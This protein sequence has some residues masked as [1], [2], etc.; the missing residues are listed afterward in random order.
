MRLRFDE[1][2]LDT[3]RFELCRNGQA[4]NIE[5]KVFD[6]LALL[7][8]HPE[9]LFSRE[10]L[11]ARV[12]HGRLVSDTTISTC[13]KGA[14]KALNDSGS[15]QTYI[16]TVRG[17]GFCFIG[18]VHRQEGQQT[19]AAASDTPPER[20]RSQAQ[21]TPTL[22][23]LPFKSITD[24]ADATTLA[25]SLGSDISAILTRLPLLRVQNRT[26]PGSESL[27]P[28]AVR[29]LHE[30]QGIDFVVDAGIQRTDDRFR[31]VIQLTD[32]RSG[33]QLWSEQFTITGPLSTAIDEAMIAIIAKLEPQLNRSI[34]DRVTAAKDS[35]PNARQLFL[36]A[37][38]LLA[39]RGWHHDTFT[40]AAG[41]LRRSRSLD[42]GFALAS[43]NLALVL[44][45]GDRFG[46]LGDSHNTR[47]EAIDA[48]EQAITLDGMDS[49]VL[50]YA[51]CALADLGN[52]AR[53]LPMLHNA[54]E[55]N[56]ANAQA[57]A[58]L[59]S[60]YLVD[61]D[62]DAAVRHLRH[63]IEIS[64]LDS[65]LSIWGAFLALA[66]LARDD[67]DGALQQGLLACRRDDRSYI[68][69]I[70]LAAIHLARNEPGP[71]GEMLQEALRIKPDLN[72]RQIN[73][74]VGKRTG[75]A[76]SQLQAA[77]SNSG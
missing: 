29:E 44:G 68:P 57:W 3:E 66:L 54:I 67:I 26:R 48:L 71:A 62:L 43:A 50:G 4:L 39:L 2:E 63:G 69:R 15:A 64:P 41:L 51:G 9:Q 46:V 20:N 47:S 17:R 77:A 65:R 37:N 59:G 16:R 12:W 76:L 72:S 40:A 34:Y 61:G 23:V 1:F 75:S 36:E 60:A 13:V 30:T 56:R 31:I 14:R 11:I 28:P 10:Q 53:A 74:L 49:T 24:D 55:V 70:I 35:P 22:A 33:F 8:Q 27:H 6:L 45:L 32:A 18:S 21:Y 52:L 7:V 58:A 25:A 38:S 42:P 73:A 19:S 5:P